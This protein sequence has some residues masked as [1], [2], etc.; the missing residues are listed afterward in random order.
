MFKV[1]QL[2]RGSLAKIS[3]H[4]EYKEKSAIKRKVMNVINALY[5]GVTCE[6]ITHLVGDGEAVYIHA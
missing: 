6:I 1:S 3:R 2:R 5:L 4:F